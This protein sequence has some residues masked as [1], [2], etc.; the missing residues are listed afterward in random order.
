MSAVMQSNVEALRVPP[1]AVQAEQYVLGALLVDPKALARVALDESDFYRRDHALVFRAICDL[2]AAGQP[3]DAVTVGEWF[4]SHDLSREIG[5][6]A[7]LIELANNAT[8]GNVVAYAEIVR[9]KSALRRAIEVGTDLVNAA[10]QP[11]G[12][13]AA[14]ILDQAIR[15]LMALSK[16]EDRCEF[17]LQQAAKL[18]WEDAQAAHAAEGR[19]RGITTGFAR[20][21]ARLGG[22]HKGDLVILGARPSMGKTALMVNMALAAAR[23]GHSVGM[24]SGEQ[25]ALQ[26]GQRSVAAESRVSAERM[27]NGQFEEEDW[28]L[29][30]QAM[31][32]LVER[33]VRLIDRSAPTLDEVAR[34][35]RR[36]KQEYGIEVLFVDYLQRIRVPRSESRIEEVAEVSRGLKTLARDLDIPVVA[37]AQVKAEVDKRAGDKRPNLGDVANSDEATREADQIGFLYRDEVYDHDSPDRGIAE[38]NIEKNRHGPTGQ[39]RLRFFAETMLF[40]NLA[41]DEA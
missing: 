29:L 18:A 8:S 22:F 41:E 32:R 2:D 20:M 5:R 14:E 11:D 28:P 12:R 3:H 25:S 30:T 21:D 16:T 19:L 31:R 15:D 26:I 7:Y 10:F 33:K 4:D 6:G 1:Q 38:L 9:E 39:F 35:A 13:R 24:V 34:T 23:A 17:T 40:A 27:R 37:L 36:W